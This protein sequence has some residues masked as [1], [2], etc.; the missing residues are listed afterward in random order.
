[1]KFELS[2]TNKGIMPWLHILKKYDTRS[3]SKL[4][5]PKNEENGSLNF[6]IIPLIGRKKKSLMW[7][8]G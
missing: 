8:L 7:N 6:G 1:M 2:S 5:S 3:N 4:H